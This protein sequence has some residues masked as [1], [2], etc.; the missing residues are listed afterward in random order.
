MLC[1]GINGF[2]YLATSVVFQAIMGY[3]KYITLDTVKVDLRE[4]LIAS[5]WNTLALTSMTDVLKVLEFSRA[6]FENRIPDAY[7]GDQGIPSILEANNAMKKHMKLMLQEYSVAT[8]LKMINVSYP[9]LVAEGMFFN[10]SK[11]TEHRWVP[12]AALDGR[13]G[14][15]SPFVSLSRNAIGYIQ[16]YI[17]RFAL[18]DELTRDR[19]PLGP[20]RKGDITE[21][22]IRKNLNGELIG[23]VYRQ[24]LRVSEYFTNVC[25]MSK[26]FLLYSQLSCILSLCFVAF[27]VAVYTVLLKQKMRSVYFTMF[28][29]RV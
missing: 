3:S 14:E 18:S 22:L 17:D 8:A 11:I 13:V 28:D 27:I 9:K 7:M 24:S 15:F 29:F 23:L 16:P 10:D 2:N 21:E 4:K 5:D 12:A 19:S 25:D 6:V 20:D 1:L 26:R